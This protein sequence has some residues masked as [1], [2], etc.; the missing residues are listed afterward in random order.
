LRSW[1]AGELP[2]GLTVGAGLRGRILRTLAER[3]LADEA[4]LDELARL[5]PVG[6]EQARAT[7]RASRPD[8]T[9]KEQAWTAALAADQDWRTA[10][11]YANGFWVPGQQ[12]LLQDYR[13]RYFR[14][15]L[16]ALEGREI[17]VMRNLARAL[18]PATLAGP[19]TLAAAGTA[20]ERGDLSQGMR[21]IVLERDAIMR[22]VL[23]ARSAKPR[24]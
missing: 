3:G 16:P 11:A 18:Y 10:L 6:G 21:L 13:D 23:A 15:A 9:A 17:R 7:G 24:W 22:S 20:V 5:D 12:E 1:L 2:A 19:E 14:V 4:D 8:A